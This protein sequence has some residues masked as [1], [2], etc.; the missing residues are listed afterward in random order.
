MIPNPGFALSIAG[1]EA[2]DSG[3]G[4]AAIVDERARRAVAPRAMQGRKGRPRLRRARP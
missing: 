3:A 1:A 2:E 4:G